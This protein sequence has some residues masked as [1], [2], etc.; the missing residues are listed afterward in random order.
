MKAGICLMACWFVVAAHGE[1][2]D[3]YICAGQ[4]NMAGARS[5]KALLPPEIQG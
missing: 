3:V 5:E 2:L 1:P 4:S